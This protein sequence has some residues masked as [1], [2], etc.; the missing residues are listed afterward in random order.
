VLGERRPGA[1]RRLGG[2]LAGAAAAPVLEVSFRAA[3]FAKLADNA[4]HAA[5]VAFANEV[6]R[7]ALAAGADPEAVMAVLLADPARNLGPTYLRPGGPY[8]GSC[9][10]KDLAALLAQAR[11]DGAA[12]LPL[13]GGV[14]ASNAGHGRWLA[15]RVRARVPPPGPVLQVG[16]SF[17]PGTDDLRGSAL[18]D[19][20]RNL[21]GAGYALLLHDPDL[22]PDRLGAACRPLGAVPL[23]TPDEALAAAAAARLVLLGKPAPDLKAR[24]PA[25]PEL[26]E[27]TGLVGF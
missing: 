9:L 22:T 13:L 27:V 15:G 18:L 7:A 25:G 3:E 8:G 26:L 17:K 20:A 24:L 1:T 23:A 6:G 10:G 11:S 4:W 5:K 12:P 21:A 2:L 19:L 16:L 14:A